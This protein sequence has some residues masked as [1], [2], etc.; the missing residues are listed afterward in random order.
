MTI[1]DMNGML[2]ASTQIDAGITE[3]NRYGV[4]TIWNCTDIYALLPHFVEFEDR[5]I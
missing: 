1:N 2:I 4:Q 5:S 3:S